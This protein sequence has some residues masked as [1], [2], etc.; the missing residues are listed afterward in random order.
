MKSTKR[1]QKI[2]FKNLK[3][4]KGIT[5]IALVITIIVL[6]ILAGVT[7]ATLTGDNGILTRAQ[8]AKN[9]TEEAEEKEGIRLAVSN[10]QI[11]D[12][13]YQQ[14]N[15]T[16]LQRAIDEQ[17]GE[18]QANVTQSNN[19][20]FIIKFANKEYEISN[21]GNI[22]EIQKVTDSTPGTLAGN[23]TETEP[24]LIESIEDLVFFA[25]DVSNGNTYEDKYVKLEYSLNFSADSSYI[26]PNIENFCGY[27]GKLKDALTSGSGFSGI[28]SIDLYESDKHFY[29]YFDGNKCIIS[30]IFINNL[31]TTNAVCIGLFNMNYGTIKDV[32]LENISIDAEFNPQKTGSATCFIGGLVGRNEGTISSVYTSGN[33]FSI[34]TGTESH[35]IR[36]GGICGQITS[37][38]ISNSYNLAN[39]TTEGNK[40]ATNPSVVGGCVGSLS[41]EASLVNSYNIGIIKENNNQTVLAGGI[42]GNN[43]QASAT[44]TN[45]YYLSGTYSVG[46]GNR[47]GVADSEENIVKSSDYMK[48]NEFV[49]LLGNS[50]FKI[51]SNKNNGYP[52]LSWQ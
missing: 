48:S 7:I 2:K 5:L 20:N 49:N 31:Y 52:V 46:I 50:Y 4:A 40:S 17:F 10:A 3:G 26:N 6:L 23:G 11:G 28:G 35:S 47:V 21:S 29:G 37:G 12:N 44:I 19:G 32:G 42:V 38:S 25:Y 30:N 22:S 51:E 14:L 27:D 18:G 24:Y 39:V 16:N 15:Q 8:E 41:T 34:Y 33:I 1:C 43:S 13:G 36:A 9:K 45:C